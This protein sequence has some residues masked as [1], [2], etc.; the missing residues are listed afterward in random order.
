[1]DSAEP[2]K[3][4]FRLPG[5]PAILA[6]FGRPV[7]VLGQPQVGF[8]YRFGTTGINGQIRSVDAE[9]VRD[10]R[11]QALVR[12]VRQLDERTAQRDPLALC[13]EALVGFAANVGNSAIADTA[14]SSDERLR[15]QYATVERCYAS[16]QAAPAREVS[17]A[18]DGQSQS[19]TALECG[20]YTGVV[21]QRDNLVI[22]CVLPGDQAHDIE[23]GMIGIPEAVL[24][25]D[26]HGHD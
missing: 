17:I 9:S 12:T 25:A 15:S 6:S 19:A 3:Q 20:D 4:P 21:T 23:L 22:I 10:N 16:I 18:I 14:L 8:D 2:G 26:W 5:L 13:A 11:S 1:M 7:A 24:G